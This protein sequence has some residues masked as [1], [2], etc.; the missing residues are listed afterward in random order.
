MGFIV[1]IVVQVLK[2]LAGSF[3]LILLVAWATARTANEHLFPVIAGQPVVEIAVADHGVHAGIVVQRADLETVATK[4][5]DPVLLAITQRFNA[6]SYLEI[7]WGDEQFYRFA[8]TL[9]AVTVKMA[10]NALA[11]LDKSTVLHIVGLQNDAKK[12][13]STRMFR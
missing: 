4:M 5:S 6:Y 7:G 9:S 10:F 2:F 11:G 12:H 8:P 1:R 13:S 3:L